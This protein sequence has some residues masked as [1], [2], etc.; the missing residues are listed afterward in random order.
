M[1]RD[2]SG[3]PYLFCRIEGGQEQVILWD[4][5]D[6][7]VGRHPSQDV[8]VPDPEVSREHARFRCQTGRHFVE[9]LQTALGTQVNGEPIKVHALA[10]GDVVRVGCLELRFGH[11]EKPLR[12]G[13]HVR[14][15]SQLKSETFAPDSPPRGDSDPD[16]SSDASERTMLAFEPDEDLAST[17]A[18]PTEPERPVARALAS[19]GRLEDVGSL[20]AEEFEIL[21][22][23][24][25][26][27]RDLDAELA[28]EAAGEDPNEQTLRVD[29]LATAQDVRIGSKPVAGDALHVELVIEGATP[30]L[31]AVLDALGGD[32]LDVGS[33]RIRIRSR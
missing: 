28:A 23:R 25:G 24:S 5:R 7:T 2:R 29:G 13:G 26:D 10:E 22:G 32:P 1:S 31:R 14:F 18:E 27:V 9:D 15:A 19:N 4:T 33:F 20:G 6:V 11:T 12:A 30:K 17:P 21:L 16:A 3:Q 8:V